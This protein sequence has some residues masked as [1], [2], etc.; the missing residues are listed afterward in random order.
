MFTYTLSGKAIENG[1]NRIT[2]DYSNGTVKSNETFFFSSKEELDN[3]ITAEIARLEKVVL[4]DAAIV[5]TGYVKTE[6]KAVAPLTALEI[7]EAELY[8]LKNLI[9][10]GVMKEADPEFEAAVIA[11]KTAASTK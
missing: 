4:L 5:T 8:R 6:P 2:V 11:Y 7:A 3:H 1:K 10:I 9:T